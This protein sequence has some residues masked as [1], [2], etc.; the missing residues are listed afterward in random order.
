[1]SVADRR[2]PTVILSTPTVPSSFRPNS[3]AQP[4][5]SIN[6]M[7]GENQ[8]YSGVRVLFDLREF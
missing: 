5:D 8:L 1:M 4:W 6:A 7:P 3:G 2:A